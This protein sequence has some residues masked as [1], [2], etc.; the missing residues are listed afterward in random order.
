HEFLTE[1]P[2]HAASSAG[3][4]SGLL[5]VLMQQGGACLWI[6]VDRTIFP[7][8]LKAFGVE[9]DRIIFIDLRHEKDVLWAMEEA[10]KCEGLSAVVAEARDINL[11]ASRR[12]QLAVEQSKVTG[13][14]LRNDPRKLSTTA[15]VAR[16]RITPLPSVLEEGMPGVGYPRWTVELLKVRNGIPG[17]WKMEWAAGRFVPIENTGVLHAS[18]QELQ[19]KAL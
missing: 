3:F 1:A 16:W 14:I 17:S 5:N 10:L 15:C 4:I 7:P 19:R 2:E 11:T 6:S 18:N 9:P 13:F 8:A 12:L